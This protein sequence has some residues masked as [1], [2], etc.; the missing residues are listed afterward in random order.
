MKSVIARY[1]CISLPWVVERDVE[2]K[3]TGP[4]HYLTLDRTYDCTSRSQDG[5]W[6]LLVRDDGKEGSYHAR[7]FEATAS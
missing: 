1:R 2:G 5:Q 3:L 7:H 6:L 4:D